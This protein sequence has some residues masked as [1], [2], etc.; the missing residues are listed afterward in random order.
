MP[1]Y[2]ELVFKESFPRKGPHTT[3]FAQF[4]SSDPAFCFWAWCGSGDRAFRTAA[5]DIA[6]DSDR[7]CLCFR[8]NQV[9]IPAELA[10][11][12]GVFLGQMIARPERFKSLFIAF[13][14]QRN[15]RHCSNCSKTFR[16]TT[17]AIGEHVMFPTHECRSIPGF[18]SGICA[19][20]LYSNRLDC[21]WLSFP[22][23]QMSRKDRGS[24]DLPFLGKDSSSASCKDFLA[25]DEFLDHRNAPRL[26]CLWPGSGSTESSA[27]IAE[28]KQVLD[29]LEHLEE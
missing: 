7:R 14:G 3:Y 25:S 15:P 19:N 29:E 6:L 23:Y 9:F 20:C 24:I 16:C 2:V 13:F 18:H 11:P 8:P 5:F 21:E 4:Q 28:A 10:H 1:I 12:N 27:G 17:T 22:G 26:T